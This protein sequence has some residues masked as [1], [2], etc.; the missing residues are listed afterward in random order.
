MVGPAATFC[1]SRRGGPAELVDGW[2]IRA[3]PT[4]RS[5][6]SSRAIFARHPAVPFLLMLA[7]ADD[8]MGLIVLAAFY[9][10]ARCGSARARS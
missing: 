2:A 10:S 8:A 5:A 7:I 4:S 3:R 6:R 9:P 1:C